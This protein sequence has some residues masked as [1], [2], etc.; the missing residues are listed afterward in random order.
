VQL[1]ATLGAVSASPDR[2]VHMARLAYRETLFLTDWS[3]P[4]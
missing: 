3:L 2:A 1:A 4:Q